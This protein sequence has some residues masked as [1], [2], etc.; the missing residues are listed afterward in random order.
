MHDDEVEVDEDLVRRLLRAQLPYLA[1]EP[2]S[3]VEPWG[4]DNAIWRLGTDLVV[5]LP[6]IHWAAKQVAF[7][8]SWL[9]YLALRL[10]ISVPEPVATGEPGEGYPFPWAVHRWLPGTVARLDALADAVAFALDLAATVRALRHTRTQGAPSAGGRARP[11]RDNDQGVR[12]AIAGAAN[13]IDSE[14]A[15]AIWEEALAAAPHDEAKVWVHGDLDQNCL[16]DKGALSGLIDWSC[17]GVGD[18]AADVAVVWSGL[19]TPASRTAF[20]EALEVDS[21][22]LARSRGAALAQACAA[23]PYYLNTYPLMVE[24]CWHRLTALGV[25]PRR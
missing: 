6:R 20:L 3:T 19:F 2:L 24:R 14:A 11:A 23:L 18:P 15:S 10:P 9:P 8:A 7:E 5:R 22:T 25:P 21:A 12:Q 1:A 4:T 16:V 13:L 17:A